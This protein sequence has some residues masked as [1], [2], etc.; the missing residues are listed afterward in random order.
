MRWR[1]ITA[2]AAGT[3]ASAAM[4]ATPSHLAWWSVVL[5]AL[6][7][8]TFLL[9]SKDDP[10]GWAGGLALQ[11]PWSIYSVL[12][13]QPAFLMTTVIVG[14]ANVRALRRTAALPSSSAA[15][16]PSRTPADLRVRRRR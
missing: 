12:S 6:Q 2:L 14:F 1:A 3:A 9:S 8:F 13:G 7:A 16:I 4:L 15:D 11:G 10:R 5:T